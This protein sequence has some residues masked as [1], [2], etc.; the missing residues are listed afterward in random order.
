[1]VPLHYVV[2]AVRKSMNNGP[3]GERLDYRIRGRVFADQLDGFAYLGY[4]IIAKTLNLTFVPTERLGNVRIR[5]SIEA[6]IQGR[7]SR[8]LAAT[9]SHE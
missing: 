4:K 5:R 2:Y 1:M 9:S 8:A 3:S 7:D 6:H